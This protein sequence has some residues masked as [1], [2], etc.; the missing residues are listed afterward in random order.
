MKIEAY[1]KINLTLD[2]VG[3]HPDG[4]HDLIMIMQSVGLHDDVRVN[5]NDSSKITVKSSSALLADDE[6]LF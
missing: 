2:I 4:Y 6:S 5:L 1:A 3:K